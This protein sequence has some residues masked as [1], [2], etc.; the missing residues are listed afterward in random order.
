MTVRFTDI[1]SDIYHLSKRLD[2]SKDSAKPC[3][4]KKKSKIAQKKFKASENEPIVAVC[5]YSSSKLTTSG[6]YEVKNR[7]GN[8]VST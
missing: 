4:N 3:I 8:V 2:D 5:V 7:Y 1:R 6:A